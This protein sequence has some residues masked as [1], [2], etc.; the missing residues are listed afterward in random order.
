MSITIN[1]TPDEERKLL[2]RAARNGQDVTAY[3]HRLIER[4]INDVDEALAPFRR[5]VAESGISD[6]ELGS[7]FEEVREEVWEEKHG[8]PSKAS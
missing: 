8:G 6:D 2:E 5:Q 4:D 3:V 7:F 1:L